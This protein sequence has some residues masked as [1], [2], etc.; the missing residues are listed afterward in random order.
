MVYIAGRS[1]EFVSN[2]MCIRV[3]RENL[4]LKLKLL[5]EYSLIIFFVTPRSNLILF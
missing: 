3:F 2:S 5:V 4:T 1:L